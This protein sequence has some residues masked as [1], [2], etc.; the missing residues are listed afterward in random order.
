MLPN[1]PPARGRGLN[2]YKICAILSS[3]AR[4][5]LHLDLDAFFC[6][7]E[8]Q[9]NPELR[10][11]AF[12]V[13]GRPD[14][15]GVVASCSY[16]ARQFGVH[17]AMPMGR[18]MRM[19][20]GLIVVP[21][22]YGAYQEM[23]RQVMVILHNLTP[24][25]EQISIDEAFLD[26]TEL[27][28]AG[29]VTAKELQQ[30]IK[31]ELNLPCSLGIA[32]NKLV[33]K[34]AN[35]IG[36]ASVKTDN[37]PNAITVIEPG[38][39]TKFLAPLPIRELWGVGPKTAERLTK[40]GI[41]TIGDI[42][43]WSEIDLARRFGKLGYDLSK[44]SKGID[45]RPV[46]TEHETKSISQETTFARDIGAERHLKQT[47]RRLSDQV[48]H[49]LRKSELSGTTIKLKIRWTD[50]TTLTR[51][52]TLSHTTDLDSEIFETVLQLF[53]QVWPPGKRVRLL[54]VGVSNFEAP[55]RQLGL[56]DTQFEPTQKLQSTLDEIKHKFGDKAV[57]RGNQLKKRKSEKD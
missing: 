26:V 11:K 15:R 57:R 40:M 28:Q 37:T 4:K 24:L 46:E 42:A 17:S 52:T 41:H 56:W 8:E 29:E 53:E 33:A 1:P 3:M 55:S 54:G 48:G 2:A 31:T 49:R 47:L 13:G 5:I 19:C 7:V 14:Q 38:Q 9:Y 51:Q 39:E 22:R 12:A 36:K 10:G 6:A 21:S 35:N 43:D 34:I 27:S 44:R 50:F 20:P 30:R 23:S 16:A 18:A 45:T 25:V 32:S